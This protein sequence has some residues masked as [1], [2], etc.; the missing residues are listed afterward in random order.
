MIKSSA[1]NEIRE[2][3]P[4]GTLISCTIMKHAPFGV[5]AAISGIPFDGLIQVYP[6]MV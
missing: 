6:L 1:W 3:L 2:K 4:I 5:F